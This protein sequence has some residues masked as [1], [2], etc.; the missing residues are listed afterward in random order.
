M[1][2]PPYPLKYGTVPRLLIRSRLNSQEGTGML[3]T[4]RTFFFGKR[5]L[6]YVYPASYVLT[7]FCFFATQNSLTRNNKRTFLVTH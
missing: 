2:D 1:V 4:V 6:F 3:Y 5:N 7:S